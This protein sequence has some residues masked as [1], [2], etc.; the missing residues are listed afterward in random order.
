MFKYRQSLLPVDP[1]H[2][3]KIVYDKYFEQF[4]NAT[5]LF[6]DEMRHRTLI[7]LNQ[8][9]KKKKSSLYI[10]FFKFLTVTPYNLNSSR[11]SHFQISVLKIETY[12]SNRLMKVLTKI[13][14]RKVYLRRAYDF[15]RKERVSCRNNV[16]NEMVFGR[17]Y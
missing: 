11:N 17:V 9:S 4:N 7:I 8:V 13:D 5:E 12:P 6:T 10:I 14:R 16:F 1:D 2:Q 15:I 3:K